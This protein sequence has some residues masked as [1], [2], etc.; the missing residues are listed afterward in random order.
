LVYRGGNAW[1]SGKTPIFE[2]HLALA[3]RQ[4]VELGVGAYALA[5]P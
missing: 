5:R 4:L 2:S 3:R 1:P